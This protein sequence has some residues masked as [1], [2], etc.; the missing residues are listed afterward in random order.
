MTPK[1]LLDDY[2]QA[3]AR[4]HEVLATPAADDLDRAGCIQ[5][6]E[7]CFELAWKTIKVV[8]ES[9]GLSGLV[10]PRACLSQAF[11]MGWVQSEELWLEMLDARNRMSHTY[12]YQDAL[13]VY[14]RLA[15]FLPEMEKLLVA[16]RSMP[17]AT[18]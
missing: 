10:S 16:L 6:F 13:V 12:K 14:K 18:S 17:G 5:Y 9:Q 3:L 8:G 15:A 1:L 7:F 2:E 4:L 11:T